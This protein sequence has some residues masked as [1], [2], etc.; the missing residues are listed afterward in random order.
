MVTALI[1]FLNHHAGQGRA[2]WVAA[3][4]AVETDTFVQILGDPRLAVHPAAMALELLQAG[5]R[6]SGIYTPILVQALAEKAVGVAATLLADAQS[7]G[8]ILA[9][10]LLT[11][12]WA[13]VTE[14][15]LSGAEC[16]QAIDCI[17]G[18]GIPVPAK[19]Q[20]LLRQRSAADLPA[21][22]WLFLFSQECDF[23]PG[24]AA[25]I[26]QA[27]QAAV[28]AFAAGKIDQAIAMV[29]DLLQ[30]GVDFSGTTLM[31]VSFCMAA[32]DRGRAITELRTIVKAQPNNISCL[33]ALADE[34]QELE[35]LVASA[36][37][38]WAA[39]QAMESDQSGRDFSSIRNVIRINCAQRRSI[40][41]RRPDHLEQAV[42]CYRAALADG[43]TDLA[44]WHNLGMAL[45]E[46]GRDDEAF[47]ALK[48]AKNVVPINFWP[49]MTRWP[50]L[51]AQ[52]AG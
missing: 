37:C 3:M 35:E 12:F 27:M 6:Q 36:D 51:S 20:D 17:H 5:R 41:H 32:G 2:D 19:V 50:D 9:D 44:L 43:V 34:Y 13:L 21:D 11:R 49:K 52:H 39:L 14:P 46:L 38:L 4:A 24:R 18:A 10:D 23:V 47:E 16:W 7:H 40:Q 25:P 29:V 33:L 45:A 26:D 30:G 15:A 48:Q 22:L 28:L 31:L 42:S 1:E 8:Q